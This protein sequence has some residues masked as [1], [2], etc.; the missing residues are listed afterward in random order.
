MKKLELIANGEFTFSSDSPIPSSPQMD[1]ILV[2]VTHAGI[3][4]SDIGRAFYNGAYH[5][6]LVMG[7]EFSA[8]VEEVPAQQTYFSEGDRVV[9]YPLIPCHACDACSV[10]NYAEVLII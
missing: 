7:H 8:I 4:N 10:G 5:Y 3:C 2:R 9:I 1:W 6:P